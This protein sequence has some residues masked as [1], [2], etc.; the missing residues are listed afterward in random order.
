VVS[1]VSVPTERLEIRR[2]RTRRIRRIVAAGMIVT[3]AAFFAVIYVRMALN[4]DPALLADAARR[5]ATR[6]P[7]ASTP[8]HINPG[9]G[10]ASGTSV[11]QNGGGP[12]SVTTHAS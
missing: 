8:S 10:N 1:S 7:A 9:P 12:G 2:R 5:V 11:P 3:F 6:T 4:K